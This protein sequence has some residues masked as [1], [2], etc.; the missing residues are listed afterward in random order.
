MCFGYDSKLQPVMSTKEYG[1][2]SFVA[3]NL[4]W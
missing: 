2:I 3:I 1:V 4:E